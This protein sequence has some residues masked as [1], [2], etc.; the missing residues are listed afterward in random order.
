MMLPT[1]NLEMDQYTLIEFFEI[2]PNTLN[3]S[4]CLLHYKTHTLQP[5]L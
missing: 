4:D 1:K 3:K 5:C 2:E